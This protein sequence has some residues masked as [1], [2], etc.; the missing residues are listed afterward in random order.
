MKNL[1]LQINTKLIARFRTDLETSGWT[2]SYLEE[3]FGQTVSPQVTPERIALQRHIA[4]RNPIDSAAIFTRL[5]MLGDKL[6]DKTLALA[7]DE[8]GVQGAEELGLIRAVNDQKTRWRAAVQIK[9][10]TARVM[11]L[12]EENEAGVPTDFSAIEAESELGTNVESALEPRVYHWW[13]ASD[14]PEVV[15]G[16]P[17]QPEHVLGVGGATSS[18]LRFTVRKPRIESWD[19]GTGCGIQ[20]LYL[21]VHSTRVLATD[22][23]RR[24]LNFAEFNAHLAGKRFAHK[25]EF[26]CGSFTDPAQ[27]RQF[28]LIV[29]NPPFVITPRAF[30]EDVGLM[31]YRDGGRAG[32]GVVAHLCAELPGFLKPGGIL[33]MLANW[34][35]LDEYW[36]EKPAGWFAG[37]EDLDIWITQR[38]QQRPADYAALWLRDGGLDPRLQRR[39]FQVGMQSWVGDFASRR[40]ERIAFGYICARRHAVDMTG[41]AGDAV[42]SN[43]SAQAPRPKHW[44]VDAQGSGLAADGLFVARILDIQ[45]HLRSLSEASGTLDYMQ[46]NWIL[47]DCV[48]EQ[49]FYTPGAEDPNVVRLVQ[50]EGWGLSLDVDPLLAG[51]VG[52][53]DGELPV[54][55]I[56]AAISQLSGIPVESIR[57][58]CEPEFRKLVQRGFLIPLSETGE[59]VHD[60]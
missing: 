22:I 37:R 43:I 53:C 33:Q 8:T 29:S 20:A 58:T 60:A 25:I 12:P 46:G 32:D 3:L 13:I 21:A 54:G 23:S 34:E 18:L 36:Q 19:L 1:P 31:E 42:C 26:L 5:F 27:G 30:R 14:L 59:E 44:F 52:A 35:V 49:R 15:T 17:V 57:E 40:V 11:V 39:E 6:S 45:Q 56:I 2:E 38:E 7:F 48:S 55:S 41:V 50:G 47:S 24:C 9:P 4:A 10:H 28:D 16:E 51:I